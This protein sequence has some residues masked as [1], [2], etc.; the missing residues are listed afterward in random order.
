MIQKNRQQKI[1]AQLKVELEE[2]DTNGNKTN[3]PIVSDL[4]DFVI[5]L[6]YWKSYTD[7]IKT[8]FEGH[9]A[10]INNRSV[11]DLKDILKW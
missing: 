3:E 6:D 7:E 11:D 4:R 2:T 9:I 10:I 1:T 8:K 5:P